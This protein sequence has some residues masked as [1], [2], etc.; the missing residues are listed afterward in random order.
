MTRG[1]RGVP[2]T[3]DRR[4]GKVRNSLERGNGTGHTTISRQ[5]AR[6]GGGLGP[7][8]RVAAVSSGLIGGE[9][10]RQTEERGQTSGELNVGNR[11]EPFSG[12]SLNGWWGRSSGWTVGTEPH[13]PWR[14]GP[15]QNTCNLRVVIEGLA[16][17]GWEVRG[18]ECL[19]FKL[20]IY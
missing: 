18:T 13:P 12:L 16:V 14:S 6:G 3:L 15:R 1:R 20:S 2:S 8:R 11:G 4:T 10:S 19:R 9:E 7:G 17:G 5:R